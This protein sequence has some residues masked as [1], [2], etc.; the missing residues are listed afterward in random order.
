M[1]KRKK[2]LILG[3][4]IAGLYAAH[5]LAKYNADIILIESS[6]TIG[7]RTSSLF[8]KNANEKIDNGQ[9]ILSGAYHYF[10]KIIDELNLKNKLKFQDKQDVYF[11]EEKK[12]FRLHSNLP[13]KLG[14]LFAILNFGGLDASDKFHILNFALKLK[15]VK[16]NFSNFSSG[17]EFLRYFGQSDRVI[18]RLWEPICLATLNAP[19]NKIDAS[20]FYIVVKTAFLGSRNDAKFIFANVELENIL[21]D[22]LKNF[23]QQGGKFLPNTAVKEIVFENG[24]CKGIISGKNQFVEADFVVS[25]LNYN[26]LVKI[27]GMEQF[28]DIQQ[29]ASVAQNSPIISAYIWTDKKLMEN[30]IDFAGFWGSGVQW[31]FNRN[32]LGIHKSDVFKYSYS[33]TYSNANEIAH[34]RT[35]EI[36]ELF[37]SSLEK[38]LTDFSLDDVKYMRLIKE[39]NATPIFTK[40]LEKIRPNPY[41]KY[42]NFLLAGDWTDTKLPATI[43]GAAK[44]GVVASEVLIDKIKK[45]EIKLK[46]GKDDV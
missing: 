40:E 31:I 8:D 12:Q 30:H 17:L 45:G 35:E 18:E 42:N 11:Y 34:L 32:A 13:T 3:A 9:H 43:E 15:F 6:G 37:L 10:L 19:L 14:N 36:K 21:N 5:S 25:A 1:T 46:K 23:F 27:K 44:S 2:I 28:S 39:K 38:N 4:G 24:R 41:T 22:I 26:K 29:F 16:L 33:L 7:G 20:L